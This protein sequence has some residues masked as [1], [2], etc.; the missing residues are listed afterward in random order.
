MNTIFKRSIELN[1]K[2]QSFLEVIDNGLLLFEK[3]ITYYLEGEKSLFQES[4]K[5]IYALENEADVLE[6]D[7][8]TSLY[9]FLLL[10]DVRADVLSLI[11]SLDNIIDALEE[12]SRDLNIQKPVFPDPIHKEIKELVKNTVYCADAI[13]KGTSAFFNELHLVSSYVGKVDFFEHE[14]DL[15]QERIADLVYNGGIVET[16]AEKNQLNT[17]MTKISKVSDEAE[18]IGAKLAI[19]TIKR[20]I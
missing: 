12:I 20:E 2:I 17:L 4:I 1:A 8:K 3:A 19:F 15:I 14:V 13:L 7:I 6:D 11:K 16:L 5:R 18:N 9:K 10:P